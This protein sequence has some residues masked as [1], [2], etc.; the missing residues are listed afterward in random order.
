MT[1]VPAEA[2][3][4]REAAAPVRIDESLWSRARQLDDPVIAL[5]VT[6]DDLLDKRSGPG[7]PHAGRSGPVQVGCKTSVRPPGPC[8]DDPS[9]RE[10]WMD[11]EDAQAFLRQMTDE[12]T[13]MVAK[14]GR[15]S[16]TTL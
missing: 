2:L 16:E 8:S 5:Y 14:S 13:E 7:R 15:A 1:L 10:E 6:I 12:L 9:K 4:I 3:L 11:A